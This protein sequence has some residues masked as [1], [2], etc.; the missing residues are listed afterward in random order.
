MIGIFQGKKYE[1]PAEQELLR[2]PL[3]REVCRVVVR[4]PLTS[5]GRFVCERPEMPR[6]YFQILRGRSDKWDNASSVDAAL[7]AA[8]AVRRLAMD[9]PRI[10]KPEMVSEFT[11]A[12]NGRTE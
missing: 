5:D 7:I 11:E 10:R 6:V 12:D 8:E 4:F 2:F 3:G 9:L 1:V